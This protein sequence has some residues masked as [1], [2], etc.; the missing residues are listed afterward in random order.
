[1]SVE[2]QADLLPGLPPLARR[3][4][5]S[6]GDGGRRHRLVMNLDWDNS[7]EGEL[8]PAMRRD[9]AEHVGGK[10]NSVQRILIE[11]AARLQ[12]YISLMDQ[13]A[14]R[15]GTLSERN[16]REYLAWVNSLRLTLREIGLKPQAAAKPLGLDDIVAGRRVKR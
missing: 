16:S 5:G 12:L 3:R 6:L 8:V 10:P 2:E 7:P 15:D 1:M 13:Q 9:L 14:A 4:P 11:R